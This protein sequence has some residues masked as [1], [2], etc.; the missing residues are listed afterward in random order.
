MNKQEKANLKKALEEVFDSRDHIDSETHHQHHG[1]IQS[2]ID[3]N[4]ARTEF[5]QRIK[6]RV[7]T[8]G[9]LG[10]LA[11]LA[12]WLKDGFFHWVKGVK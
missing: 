4:N 5:W 8:W 10:V 3:R 1:Y 2:C 11:L 12:V 7:V 6:T 9:I